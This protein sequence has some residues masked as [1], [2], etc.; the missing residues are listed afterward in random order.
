MTLGQKFFV[1][2]AA[3][4]DVLMDPE[5]IGFVIAGILG[6]SL[7]KFLGYAIRKFG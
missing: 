7:G 3:D 2:L 4:A 5:F 1:A 6:L